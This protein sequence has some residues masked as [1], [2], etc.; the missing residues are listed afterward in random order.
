[1][2][3]FLL[4]LDP[5][6]H[7]N[8]AGD[9]AC[10]E[11]EVKKNPSA[12]EEGAFQVIFDA[13]KLRNTLYRFAI[14]FDGKVVYYR[15]LAVS[16]LE[17]AF[18]VAFSWKQKYSLTEFFDFR[19]LKSAPF[20][21]LTISNGEVGMYAGHF[22]L[23][24][25]TEDLVTLN[26]TKRLKKWKDVL[27]MVRSQELGDPL[28]PISTLEG[29]K[30]WQETAK[31]YK[32][33]FEGNLFFS[34]LLNPGTPGYP[35]PNL[36][37][38]YVLS[39]DGEPAGAEEEEKKGPEDEPKMISNRFPAHFKAPESQPRYYFTQFINEWVPSTLPTQTTDGLC[40][41]NLHYLHA[42][43][44]EE[45]NIARIKRKTEELVE[46]K[47]LEEVLELGGYRRGK[48]KKVRSMGRRRPRQ[49]DPSEELLK[50]FKKLRECLYGVP[51]Y[52]F[53]Y[54]EDLWA[55]QQKLYRHSFGTVVMNELLADPEFAPYL[56][57][58]PQELIYWVQGYQITEAG[59][60]RTDR[61]ILLDAKAKFDVTI[62]VAHVA[63]PD[64]A[65]ASKTSKNC[66]TGTTIMLKWTPNL[67]G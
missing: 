65:V 27:M 44:A 29:G 58:T 12:A 14:T 6:N 1:M 49:L 67:K 17:S 3:A 25:L 20:H 42:D 47:Q 35:T 5:K 62:K 19:E 61:F 50:I 31:S 36:D 11:L 45:G 60:Q 34:K 53:K 51:F 33:I 24:T 46:R 38:S 48:K 13:K 40:S 37:G 22:D 41:G 55:Q 32:Y 16:D 57:R 8:G 30:T 15:Q 23:N 63:F 9:S 43:E 18:H 59:K 54:G 2:R 52:D 26:C 10:R 4:E 21:Q 39:S 7:M 64:L 66:D 56:H 28:I